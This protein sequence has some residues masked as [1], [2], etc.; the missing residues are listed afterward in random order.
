MSSR[1]FDPALWLSTFVAAAVV[2][3]SVVV[4][5]GLVARDRQEARDAAG[6]M[7]EVI[8]ARLEGTL[9]NLVSTLETAAVSGSAGLDQRTAGLRARGLITAVARVE[10]DGRT[11]TVLVGDAA[12][13]E[14]GT[15]PVLDDARDSGEGR[16]ERSSGRIGL[17]VVAPV[18]RSLPRGTAERRSLLDGYVLA[19]VDASQ[20]LRD[21]LPADVTVGVTLRDAVD[22]VATV[23]DG[24][25]GGPPGR[26]MIEAGG[27]AYQLTLTG[28]P[29]PGRFPVLPLFA[30]G[31]AMLLWGA[32][33]ATARGR[34]GAERSASV[35]GEELTLLANLGALLQA[36]LDLEVILPTAAMWLS[37]QLRLDGFAVLRADRRGRLVYAF[38]LGAAPARDLEGVADIAP[39]PDEVPAGT[40]AVFPLQRAGR[41]TGALWLRPRRTLDRP[42][43]RSVNAATDLIAAALANADA[44]D[45][46]RET[47]RRLEELDRIKNRFIGTV[48]HEMRTSASAISGFASLLSSRWER[49]DDGERRDLVIRIDRNGQSLV[50][51]VED[52]L[53]FSR[54]ERRSPASDPPPASLSDLVATAVEDVAPLA[55]GHRLVTRI[56]PDVAAFVDRPAVDRILANLVSNAAKYSPAGTEITIR[57]ERFGDAALLAV[58]DEGSGIPP[59]ERERVFEA[60]YR[61]GHSA[62]AGTHGAGI[63]LAV[64][65]EVADRLRARVSVEDGPGGGARLVVAFRAAPAPAPFSP[66]LVSG[67]PDD[68]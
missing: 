12:A 1:R 13:V 39:A 50:S 33:T 63:G 27:Q 36:S 5:A 7:A 10:K 49:L 62:V 60:F 22:V 15:I 65:K 46:E 35:R 25:R 47:V 44:F 64:V 6:A 43:V 66:A 32:G 54:L 58:E 48:S 40:D 56:T 38:S 3:A 11:P 26:Q 51:V 2:I 37:E 4:H 45:Q 14:P 17:V 30:V 59:G 41:V 16:L 23:G 21:S 34:R 61:A 9:R 52:F 24:R 8:S 19:A 55:T 20:L 29:A 57:V 28:P 18:Y 31:L 42:T 67:G 68:H 53:D